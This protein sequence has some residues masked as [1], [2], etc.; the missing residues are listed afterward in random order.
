MPP[1]SRY[2]ER[3]D[4]EAILDAA[5]G[6]PKEQRERLV[7]ALSDSLD[8]SDLGPYWENEIARRIAETDAGGI[9]TVPADEVFARIAQRF[10]GA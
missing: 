9:A 1:S 6:L 5:L 8:A 4:P 2:R 3:M 10:R 7:D